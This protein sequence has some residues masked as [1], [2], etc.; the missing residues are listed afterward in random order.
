MKKKEEEERLID[1]VRNNPKLR[2]SKF[3]GILDKNN[4]QLKRRTVNQ[5]CLRRGLRM[6]KNNYNK[7]FPII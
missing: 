5:Y 7:K 1:R 3:R 2:Y 6:Y 4:N